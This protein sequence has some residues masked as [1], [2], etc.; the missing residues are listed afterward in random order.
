MSPDIHRWW[1]NLSIDAKH[2]LQEREGEPLLDIV[3]DEIE[4][5]TGQRPASHA[6]LTPEAVEFIRTQREQ[7]D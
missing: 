4:R 5:I 1:P 7:V 2:A 6:R 3:R